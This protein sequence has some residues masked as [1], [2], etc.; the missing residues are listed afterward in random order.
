LRNQ[1]SVLVHFFVGLFAAQGLTHPTGYAVEAEHNF[2]K[3]P[4]MQEK[5]GKENV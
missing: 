4:N 5:G 1:P 2:V 3:I